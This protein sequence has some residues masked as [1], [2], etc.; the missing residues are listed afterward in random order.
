LFT[1]VQGRAKTERS[2]FKKLYRS[3]LKIDN[4]NLDTVLALYN[5]IQDA[6]GVRFAFPYYHDVF[7]ILHEYV[8]PQFKNLGYVV[9]LSP[10]NQNYFDKGDDLGRRYYLFFVK[11]PVPFDIFGNLELVRAEVEVR[12]EFQH[13]WAS[14]MHDLINTTDL[15]ELR[16]DIVEDMR[17][18]SENLRSADYFLSNIYNKIKV[19]KTC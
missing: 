11:V 9:N 13:V 19:N 4:L 17:R 16:N 14:M 5:E 7:Q 1:A 15:G 18:I 10:E 8:Y 12:T 2:F 6:A 3:C